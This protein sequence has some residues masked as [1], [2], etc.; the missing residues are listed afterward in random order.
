MAVAYGCFAEL[1]HQLRFLLFE[2][3]IALSQERVDFFISQA[4]KTVMAQ[5]QR[6]LC[7]EQLLDTPLASHHIDDLLSQLQLKAQQIKQ[8]PHLHSFINWPSL[9]ETL[10]ELIA[11]RAMEQAYRCYW[12]N[13]LTKQIQQGQTFWD[14]LKILPAAE[15]LLLLEQWASPMY[16]PLMLAKVPVQFSRREVLQNLPHFRA[17]I[18]IHWGAIKK[19]HAQLSVTPRAM[20][21]LL[22]EH[23]PLEYTRWQDKLTINH[24]DC[25]DYLPLPIHPWQWRTHLQTT[26]AALIA[27]KNFIL[28]PHHQQVMPTGFAHAVTALSSTCPSMELSL[29]IQTQTSI[30]QAPFSNNKGVHN[31]WFTALL[32]EL[33]PD[34]QHIKLITQ[35]AQVQTKATISELTPQQLGVSFQQNPHQLLRDGEQLLPFTSVLT[36]SPIT[37][38]PLLCDL[39][40]S[41]TSKPLFYFSHYAHNILASHLYLLLQ[42]GTSLNMGTEN[43]LLTITDEQASGLIFK[44]HQGVV[45]ST[46]PLFQKTIKPS[47]CT[48]L[49]CVAGLEPV[50]NHFIEHVLQNHLSLWVDLLQHHYSLAADELWRGVGQTL[51]DLLIP[52]HQTLATASINQFKLQLFEL[53]WQ[54]PCPLSHYL[55]RESGPMPFVCCT[56][57][58]RLRC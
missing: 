24:L 51:E 14:H 21:E 15:R 30:K 4:H 55:N 46:H 38:R 18:T 35:C 42:H 56:N 12:N 39:I 48:N 17:K 44:T 29:N 22:A 25:A 7:R 47:D 1:S 26:Y 50:F 27:E 40:D 3:G 33:P 37:H 6:A 2:I 45:I 36:L 31:A 49:E 8:P 43:L 57:P 16:T 53:P 52:Y 5:I 23:F 34:K 13:Q 11:N 58:L 54:Q 20:N 41:S 28:F 32:T 10:N 9:K 19:T